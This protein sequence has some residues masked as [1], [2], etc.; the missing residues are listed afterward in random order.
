MVAAT[1]RVARTIFQMTERNLR[2]FFSS[3]NFASKAARKRTGTQLARLPSM[4]GTRQSK[5]AASQSN[6]RRG[7]TLLSRVGFIRKR[8]GLEDSDGNAPRRTPAGY[9]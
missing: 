5:A 8:P 9:P 4:V 6:G 7:M 2:S 1:A 3:K